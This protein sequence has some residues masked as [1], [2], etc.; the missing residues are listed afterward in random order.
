[1]TPIISSLMKQLIAR[2]QIGGATKTQ[3][4]T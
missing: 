1:M 4:I 2:V 3:E